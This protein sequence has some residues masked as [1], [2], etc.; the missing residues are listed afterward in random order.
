MLEEQKGSRKAAGPDRIMNEMLMY[1]VGWLVE[2]MV[3]DEEC[4]DEE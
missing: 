4:G 2:V 1:G 3:A